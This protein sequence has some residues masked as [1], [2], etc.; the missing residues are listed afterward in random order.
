MLAYARSQITLGR[1][2]IIMKIISNSNMSSL[3]HSKLLFT[4]TVFNIIKNFTVCNIT[5][6]YG[7]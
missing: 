7:T 5:V 3:L 4:F 1:L 2:I 6:V